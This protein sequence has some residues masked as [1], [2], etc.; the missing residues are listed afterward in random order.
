MSEVSLD[1]KILSLIINDK[2]CAMEV[3]N[4]INHRYFSPNLQWLFEALMHFYKDP[5]LKTVPTRDMLKEYVGDHPNSESHLD[6]YDKVRSLVS[7]A[8]EFPWLLQKLQFRYNNKVQ[9]DVAEKLSGILT[10]KPGNKER[11]EEVNKVLKQSIVEIDSI[12]RRRSYKEGSLQG[13]ADER[14]KKYN[15]VKDHPES[16]RGILTGFSAFDR[17][18][19]G[20][21]PG[22]F[23]IIAG[24]T[25]T[26]KSVLMHNMAVN[27][28]LGNNKPLEIDPSKCDDSGKHVLYFSLEMPKES[29]ERRIDA[30]IAGIYANHIRDGLLSDDDEKK[31]FKALEFQKKY[32]KSIYIVDMPKGV[33]TR[34]IELKYIEVCDTLFKP[35]LVVIDYL[36]IMSAN[37][38]EGQNQDWMNLGII[39]AELHEFSRIYEISTITG[40]QVNR[41]KDGVEQYGTK[42]IARSSMVPNNANIV[43]QIACR[44]DEDLRTDMVIYMVK[45]RDGEKAAFTL[46]KNFGHMRV[47]DIVNESM[48]D[49]ESEEDVL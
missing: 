41:T 12:A 33:T 39:S 42:R 26:G 29:M 32:S 49:E 4:S 6:I 47:V 16:A 34:E 28:Y 8:A 37:D 48:V 24:D 30:C 7:D 40:S 2:K 13:S 25:G 46:S 43:L 31:Y 9:K 20:L 15:Y 14:L 35:D 17:I 44:E 21:H 27:A 23:L 22:E 36:G 11:V 38:S 1:E 19:N 3:S 5:V 45:C 10:A 18:T